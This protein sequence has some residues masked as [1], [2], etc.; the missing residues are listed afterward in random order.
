[1]IYLFGDSWGFSYR[2][3]GI[4]TVADDSDIQ[5]FHGADLSSLMMECLDE[6]VVNLCDRGLSLFAILSRLAKAAPLFKPGDTVVVIQTDPLRSYF[7]PWWNGPTEPAPTIT[8]KESSNM[9]MVCDQLLQSFYNRLKMLEQAF[10]I[11]IVLHGGIGS[12]NPVLADQSDIAHTTLSSSQVILTNLEESYFFDAEYVSSNH[13]F[14]LEN[15]DNYIDDGS[16]QELIR[17]TKQ[18]NDA[19][20][21]NLEYFTF[22]HTTE[23]GTRL[24]A[25]YLSQFITDIRKNESI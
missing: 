12:I 2:Q 20:S 6:R 7:I 13:L 21:N 10:K 16:V 18:K 9:Q 3:A 24:V 11:R 8:L 23:A 4:Q 15:Y 22:N 14:L 5:V 25:H 1:M 17:V 19:W